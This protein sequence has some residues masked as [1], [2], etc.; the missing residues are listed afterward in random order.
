MSGQSNKLMNL[1]FIHGAGDTSSIWGRQKS[2]FSNRHTVLC[3][4]L[5]GR[6][7]RLGEAPFDDHEANAADVLRSMKEAKIGPAVVVGHS[8]GGAVALTLALKS[9][10][11]CLGLVLVASGARLKMHPDFL[12]AAKEKAERDPLRPPS[13]PPVPL[14]KAVA[15]STPAEILDWLRPR[16]ATASARATYGDFQA[17]DGFDVRER[18]GQIRPPTLV[19]AAG[20]DRMAPVKFGE[21]LANGIRDAKLVVIAGAAHYPM[22]EREAEFN[23]VLEAF[24][25]ELG[26]A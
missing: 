16:V 22:V 17:N 21:F 4:D 5:P 1:V 8:M 20:D 3:V 19:I 6:G 11:S 15:P 13:P 9:P 25:N 23:R 10:E 14:E 2:C 12:A 7:E 26:R 18:L 24:V